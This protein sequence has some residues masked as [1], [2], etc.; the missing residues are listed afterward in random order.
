MREKLKDAIYEY[1]QAGDSPENGV[2]AL[3]YKYHDLIMGLINV[4]I[5]IRL[6]SPYVWLQIVTVFG[7][8]A[9]SR[10]ER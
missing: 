1:K 8:I 5:R 7:K 3:V 9:V 2:A 4:S 10:P 6:W